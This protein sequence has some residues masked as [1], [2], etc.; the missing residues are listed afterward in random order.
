MLTI[1]EAFFLI[2]LLLLSACGE[3]HKGELPIPPPKLLGNQRQIEQGQLLFKAHCAECHGSLAEGRTHRTAGF[4]L[5]APDFHELRYRTA[6]PG[7]LYLRIEHG[8]RREPFRSAGSV[9]PPWGQHLSAE[10]IWELVAFIRY[11]A[12]NIPIY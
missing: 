1:K 7:Y 9:M 12:G 5:A 2:L 4:S 11:R 6:I 3:T 10:Q 8:N